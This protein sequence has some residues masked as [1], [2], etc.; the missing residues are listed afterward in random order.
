M[1]VSL[2]KI[3]GES[4]CSWRCPYVILYIS[5]YEEYQQDNFH[6]VMQY[7]WQLYTCTV[8]QYA[9]WYLYLP[10]EV[11]LQEKFGNGMCNENWDI[12]WYGLL[13]N[14]EPTS[15]EKCKT[16]VTTMS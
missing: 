7:I 8:S 15:M 14:M 6:E 16:E 2:V 5:H 10:C 9:Q 1:T 4:P 13:G 12:W 11:K 3:I